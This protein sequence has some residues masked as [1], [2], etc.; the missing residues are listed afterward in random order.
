MAQKFSVPLKRVIKEFS[1]EEVF[2]PENIDE[3]SV[4]SADLNRPGLQLS[5]FYDYFDNERIQ[6]IG[7]NEDSFLET[8]IDRQTRVER[9][10]SQKPPAVVITRGLDVGDHTVELA[11]KYGVPILRTGEGTSSFM[12]ALIAFLSIELAPRITRHGVLV[13]VYGEGMLIIGESG[14]GKSETAIE[15]IKRGH[16]LIAD[17][18]VEIRRVSNKT[19]V[20]TPPENIRHFI[21]LRGTRAGASTDTTDDVFKI[22]TEENGTLVDIVPKLPEGGLGVH[23]QNILHFV[24]V[25]NGDAQADFVP[26][27]GVNMVK[28]LEAMYKSAETGEE[29][30]ADNVT[31]A[32]AA[33]SLIAFIRYCLIIFRYFIQTHKCKHNFQN[34]QI[35]IK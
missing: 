11:K 25:V 28:I 34:H 15:L 12:A 22:F 30:A 21:E 31:N 3:I 27:Q 24:D 7:K 5:G 19:L 8:F 13:E 35:K 33:K 1:L 32:T 9:L 18:A 6:I 2:V 16:R 20:G 29:I 14:V 26:V 17:D 10:L 23:A 4:S